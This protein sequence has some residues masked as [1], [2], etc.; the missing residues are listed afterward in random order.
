MFWR[1]SPRSEFITARAFIE[2]V[3]F[4]N[5]TMSSSQNSYDS[6][7][8]T[9]QNLIAS[10]TAFQ[11]DIITKIAALET[12]IHIGSPS[13]SPNPSLKVLPT[14]LKLD[15]PWFNGDDPASWILKINHFFDFHNTPEDQ[16]L[17]LA[18]FALE[19]EALNW[20]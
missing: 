2:S 17:Q 6:L 3:L 10:Q 5:L 16:R 19:G 9:I 20:F 15:L 12:Q 18:A 7:A 4:F 13:T 14:S 1:Y 11:R 8:S